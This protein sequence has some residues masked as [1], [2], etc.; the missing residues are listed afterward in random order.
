MKEYRNN[1]GE[2]Y[3]NQ[4]PTLDESLVAT[5]KFFNC[6]AIYGVGGD[7]AANL[8]KAFDKNLTMYPSSNEMHASFSACGRAESK[9]MGVSLTT[10]T[11]GSLP[12]V[13][14]A[15]LAKSEGLPVVFI[16]GAPGEGEVEAGA[17]HHT[18]Y[19]SNDMTVKFDI[20]LNAFK[21]IGIRAERLQGG[22]TD[23]RPS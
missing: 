14:A 1:F 4:L 19:A 11:V 6:T 5:L 7:Y 2:E 17:L 8:L 23:G 18:V 21:A 12:C 10:Y 9:G 16:S 15:A 13:S 20:A 3:C 22:S